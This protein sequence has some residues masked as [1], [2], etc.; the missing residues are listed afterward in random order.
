MANALITP[1]IIAQEM[2]LQVDNNL[3]ASKLVNRDYEDEFRKV[4][5]TIS[6]RR[7]VKFTWRSGATASAQDI[8]EGNIS[9]QLATQGGVDFSISSKDLTLTVEKFSERY[10]KPAAITMANQVDSA[11]LALASQVS[12]YATT[13]G[14]GNAINSFAKF[15]V[16]PQRLDENAV[17]NDRRVAVIGPSDYWGMVGSV[18]GLYVQDDAKTALERAKLP[19]LGG[20]DVYMSQ[21]VAAITTGARGGTPLVNGGSQNVTYAASKSTWTQSLITDGWSN[22]ITG[23]VKAGDVFTMSGVFDVNPVTKVAM[24]RLKQFTVMADANSNGSGQATLTI[25]PPIITS[26]PQQTCSAAPAD[27]IGLTMLGSA[28]TA[29]PGNL[30]FHPSAFALAVRPLEIPPGASSDARRVTGDGLSIRMIPFYDATN[31][32]SLFRFDVL[33]GVKCVF[34]ELATRISG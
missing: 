6:I 25:S 8:E 14:P 32:V 29:Y 5:D 22:S 12:N 26:G 3:V 11:V 10:I 33:Y 31:D 27:N 28:S 1:S 4:G 20:T 30:V 21:N 15:A 34:P 17:P 13:S 24:T 2:M 7:P 18:S 16:G 9:M 23:V 19:M